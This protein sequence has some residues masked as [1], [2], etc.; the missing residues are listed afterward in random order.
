MFVGTDDRWWLNAAIN[1]IPTSFYALEAYATGY[2]QAATYLGRGLNRSRSRGG[3]RL[4]PDFCIYPLVFLWRHYL[5]LR[6]KEL[7]ISLSALYDEKR[8]TLTMHDLG[9]LWGRLRPLIERNRSASQADLRRAHR[10]VREFA[11]KDPTSESFRYQED[12]KGNRSL[13]DVSLINIPNVNAKMKDISAIL[14][15]VS[16]SVS[17][18]L[19][20]KRDME[21]YYRGSA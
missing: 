21:A 13:A 6:M 2:L 10:I 9:T 3:P 4:T 20:D 18:Q 14:E 17:V 1:W 16:S 5:E 7:L 12:K 8:P 19:E 15:A 11:K